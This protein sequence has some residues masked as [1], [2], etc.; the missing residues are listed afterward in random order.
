MWRLAGGALAGCCVVLALPV[1]IPLWPWPAVSGLLLLALAGMARAAWLG[2]F[3]VGALSCLVTLHSALDDRLDP[4]LEGEVLRAR[5]TVVNVPQG[6]LAALRFRFAPD[7]AAAGTPR[8]PACVELTWYDAPSRVLAGERLELELKL[9]R[10]R[11][12]ANP[13]AR[14]NEARMLRER[15]GASGYVRSGQRLG[16]PAGTG[17]RHPVLLLRARVADAVRA[18]LGE[19][20]S[21]GIV[22]GLAVGLQDALSREQ[23]LALSRSGTS[24]LMA[25]SGLHIAMVAA[26][27]AWVAARLQRLRQRRGALGAQRDAALLAGALAALGYSLLAGWSVPTQRTMV[28]IAAGALAL[29]LRRRVGTSDGFGLCLCAVLLLDPLAPLAPG[30]WLS[31][32]AVAVLLYATGGYVLRAPGWLQYLRVQGVVTLGL[33]PAL[34]GSFGA[35]SVVSAL[36][37]LYA[38]PLYTLVVVP[39]VLVSCVCVLVWPALGEVLLDWTGALIEAT[40]PS[41]DGP[42]HWRLA[43]WHVAGLGPRAWTALIAGSVAVLSPLPRLGRAAGAVLVVAA[44]LAR[45]TPVSQGSARVT[46]LDV[47]QGLAVVV[48]TRRHAL[49]Y[50]AGPSFRSGSDA[51]QLVVA[52]FLHHR[53]IRALDMLVVSHDDDD[54]AGGA[55][56]VLGL[57]PVA[58]L[59]TGPSLAADALPAS[60]AGMRRRRCQRGTHWSWDGVEFAWLH[61]GPGPYERD[62]DGSCVLLVRAGA[63]AALVTGDVEKT[64]EAEMLAAAVAGP[65]DVMVVPHHGSR[66]SSTP[67][68]VGATRPRWAIYAAG[69]HNRWNFPA[70][71]VVERWEGVGARGLR[72]GASGATAFVLGTDGPL[73]PEEW[74]PMH[75]RPWRDP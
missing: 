25:I 49:V 71:A 11:G 7:R 48:E 51:G 14:D 72:T 17:W 3:V 21:A 38:I 28:M 63:H 73:A 64:A 75:P 74:R 33:T 44:C 52:P 24:H 22:A 36:V 45:P 5:G 16:R 6:T 42:A 9:R 66:S 12:F 15:V 8:L 4:A 70:A 35:V 58:T 26:V 57:L 13:G 67:A 59:V 46:V 34:V 18:A 62:N 50:D 60:D 39:A 30:F 31:F 1:A 2:A 65:V 29:R 20:S 41:I 69:H 27:A 37:N 47:G 55:A 56:S 61:P 23:W 19:R 10:P 53:G 32:G 43:T 68:L 54:H 40:W